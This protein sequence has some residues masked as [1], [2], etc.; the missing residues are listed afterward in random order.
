MRKIHDFW[1]N[2]LRILTITSLSLCP[3]VSMNAIKIC[4]A[5]NQYKKQI[6]IPFYSL[7]G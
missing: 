3:L 7:K 1:I 2:S 5:N 4:G 6:K